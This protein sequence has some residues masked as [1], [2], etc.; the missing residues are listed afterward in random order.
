M[1]LVIGG[2]YQGKKEYVKKRYQ[3]AES[4]VWEG[5]FPLPDGEWKCINGLHKVIC[6]MMQDSQ[7][8]AADAGAA[9][10][11]RFDDVKQY[12]F[13]CLDE[14]LDRVPDLV[15]I[16]D[17]VGGGIV[18]VRKDDRDYREC[19][20]RVL[21]ELA[22]QADEV[23]RV[24][25]GIG[26]IIK[27]TIMVSLI[28]HGSTRGNMEKRY[29]G[30]TDEPLCKEGI[31]ALEKGKKEGVYPHVER[32]IASPMKRCMETAWLLYGDVPIQMEEAFRETDFGA[33]E[34]K[35]SGELL[36]DEEC[37]ALYQEW[38]DQNGRPPFPQGESMEQVK[39]RCADAF[40]RL[41]PALE[42]DTALVVHGGTIMSILSVFAVPQKDFYAYQCGNGEG[43]L[44]RL[45]LTG[46]RRLHRMR[47]LTKLTL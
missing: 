13:Q 30:T 34:G 39:K 29:I 18:P 23:V 45:E 14:L 40:M 17:E 1:R 8:K 6:Q 20:G 24:H 32:V 9:E 22:D 43:F 19:V 42:E 27:R 16:C 36:K 41:V 10:N 2:A 11:E 28:R 47:V 37:R 7:K 44:C 46:D 31:E 12:L 35:T 26:Q 4:Q 3:I 21:C 25:C 38:I 15:I 33:F 5:G